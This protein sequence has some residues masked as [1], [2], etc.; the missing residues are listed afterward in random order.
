MRNLK[1]NVFVPLCLVGYVAI[2]LFLPRAFPLL[3]LDSRSYI[4]FATTRTAIYPSFVRALGWLGLGLQQITYVQL[5]L[6][7]PAL[8][9]LI[10]S[11]LRWGV[12]RIGIVAFIGG[13]I[14]SFHFPSYHWTIMTES[15]FFTVIVIAAACCLDYLRTSRIIFLSGVCACV[16]VLAAIRPAGLTLAPIIIILLRLKWHRRDVSTSAAV[17]AIVGSVLIGPVTERLLFRTVHGDQ[18][19]S[20]LPV[21]MLGKAAM[22]VRQDMVFTGPHAS[23]LNEL[24]ERLFE[25]YGP[26]QT[27]LAHLPSLVAYPVETAAYEVLAQSDALTTELEAI[28]A[29]TGVSADVLRTELGRQAIRHN[30][31]GFIRLS[32][33][34]YVGQWSMMALRFPPTSRAINAYVASNPNV[35]F[36]DKIGDLYLHPPA[37]PI[38]M[39]VYPSMLAIG[40]LTLILG[41][42]T[43]IYM[44]RPALGETG[45]LR[46]LL[47]A[48]VFATTVHSYAFAISLVNIATP[49]YLVAVYPLI[50]LSGIFVILAAM[51]SRMDR[52]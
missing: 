32:L 41:L 44:V 17:V 27:Y 50:L 23:S 45:P 49:R 46:D 12:P 24:R 16:G 47:P 42:F 11:M 5:V 39:L 14:A 33:T 40:G 34:H 20:L 19:S 2:A 43:A 13:L 30:F 7:V 6:F 25:T 15:I 4:E 22:L 28:A 36:S 51:R 10:V 8:A 29:K 35:P 48:A 3:E 18:R 21:T 37:R 1:A 9:L 26:V 38:A 52:Q 31:S